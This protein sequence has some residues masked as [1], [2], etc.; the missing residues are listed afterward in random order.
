MAKKCLV[1]FFHYEF[2]KLD[3]HG[4][5]V[6]AICRCGIMTNWHTAPNKAYEAL[7]QNHCVNYLEET[8]GEVV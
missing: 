1:F 2:K 7:L 4:R 3:K 6:R 8:Y 5:C